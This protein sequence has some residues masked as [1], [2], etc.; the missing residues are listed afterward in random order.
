MRIITLLL[1]GLFV[2]KAA[3]QTSLN[4]SPHNIKA[5]CGVIYLDKGAYIHSSDAD[6][7]VTNLLW[8]TLKQGSGLEVT[9]KIDTAATAKKISGAY[10]LKTSPE[11]IQVTGYDQRGLFYGLQTLSQLITNG[12][13]PVVEVSDYP[14]VR[15]RGSV[16][17]FYGKPWSHRDRIAQLEFYGKNKLNTYIYGPKDDPYHSSPNWRKAYPADQAAQIAELARVAADNK[18][19]FVWA[20][21]PGQD[22]RWNEADFAIL[23]AKFEAMY[24]LGVRSFAIFF[25]DIS[26]DGTNPD[27]QAELLNRLNNEFVKV[28]GDVTP[29]IMCPTEYNKSWANPSEDGYLPILGHKL[30]PSI[31]IMWTGDRVCADITTQTLEW[32]N[33]RINRKAYIWWNFPVTDY[34]RN[35]VVQGPSYGLST[36]AQ[37]DLSGFVSNPM[38]NAEASK[39][40]L[41]GV[42]DYCWNV[43]NYNYLNSW[44]RAIET[45]VPEAPAAYRTFAIHSSDLGPNGHLYRRDE[46]WESST[47]D[48]AAMKREFEKIA[49]A[50]TSII[51]AGINPYLLEEIKPWLVEFEKLGH[52]GLGAIELLEID[53]TGDREAFWNSYIAQVLSADG[54]RSYN[55]HKSGSLVMQPFIDQI[56]DSLSRKFFSLTTQIAQQPLPEIYTNIETMKNIKIESID[57]QILITPVMESLPVAPGEY[58]GIELPRIQKID[59][60]DFSIGVKNGVLEYSKDGQ[61]WSAA[62]EEARYVRFINRTDQTINSRLRKFEI[63]ILTPNPIEF[64]TDKNFTTSMALDSP[65]RMKIE[66]SKFTLLMSNAKGAEISYLNSR[67]KIIGSKIKVANYNQLNTPRTAR[68]IIIEKASSSQAHICEILWHD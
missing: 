20:I 22:I 51:K 10:L 18:V 30:D 8:Q 4:P 1:I 48:T 60:V 63:T 62:A 5:S 43:K 52:R 14:D 3:A 46:S 50:P 6:Q 40:A 13:L 12:T 11:E 9:L 26:G 34:C 49:K 56:L 38:E 25:D 68:E 19:D 15:F 55:A 66:S 29:L 28:K 17:G 21:H 27:R 33:S 2:S 42:A 54:R 39:I 45:I 36:E 59:T 61:Q 31:E 44:E 65:L 67:G 32:I 23:K 58:Y 47:S 57:P 7:A 24:D 16:E 53:K 37:D 64:V 35:M 41:Y